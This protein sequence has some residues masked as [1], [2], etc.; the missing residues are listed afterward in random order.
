[1]PTA[2]AESLIAGAGAFDG[3]GEGGIVCENTVEALARSG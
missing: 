1:L 3:D 2:S